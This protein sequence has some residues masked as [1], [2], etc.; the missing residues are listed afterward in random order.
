MKLE[1]ELNQNTFTDE[2]HKA[3]L[4]VLVTAAHLGQ[5]TT[6]KL[7]PFNISTQQFN[8][9]RILRGRHP[10]PATIKILADRMIDKM[11]NASR[12]VE[13]LKQKG[14][15]DRSACAKD[16]RKVDIFITEA[17]LDL[18]NKASAEVELIQNKI[19]QNLDKSE[20]LLLS[21]LLDKLRE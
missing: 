7:K 16:R 11:S 12:L 3:F 10:E 18:L 2:Y 5:E 1:E 9:L 21:D 17:G 13:K 8:I 20:A 14:L 15:V 4:N 19:S 6:R